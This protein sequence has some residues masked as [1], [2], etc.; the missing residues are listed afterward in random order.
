MKQILPFLI[1]IIS[2]SCKRNGGSANDLE[3]EFLKVKEQFA[4]QMTSHFPSKI[5]YPASFRYLPGSKYS[6]TN[7]YLSVTHKVGQLDSLM[8]ELKSQ[9][10]ANYSAADSCLLIINRFYRK[11]EYGFNNSYS[12]KLARAQNCSSEHMPVPNFYHVTNDSS[13]SFNLTTDFMLFVIDA[14]VGNYSNKPN[15]NWGRYMPETW[16]NGYSK[17]CAISLEKKVALFWLSIW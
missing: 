4:P 7:I 9:A 6:N 3:S 16:K 5:T 1:I 2:I 15:P 8:R 11:T 17:G 12:K 10:I 14:R 13:E